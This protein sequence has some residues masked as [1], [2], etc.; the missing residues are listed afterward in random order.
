MANLK[1]LGTVSGFTELAA[2]DNPVPT[3]FVLPAT[4]GTAGQVLATNGNG[5]LSFVTASG[6]S[7]GSG[8]VLPTATTSVLGGVRVD[9][10]TITV[11]GTGV[12][13]ATQYTLPTASSTVLGGV[14]VGTGLTISNG[15]LSVTGGGGSSGGDADRL[16]VGSTYRSA[17]V[18]LPTQGTPFTIACRDLDGNLNAVLFQ[19]TAT[20][21]LFADL[22]E[23]YIADDVYDPGTVLEFGGKFEVTVAS[24]ETT[25][26]AGVVS[27]N[28]GFIMNNGL[29]CIVTEGERT[30][31]VALQGRVPCKV[32]GPVK[33]GDLLVSAGNGF[34]KSHP[35][36][37]LGTVIGKSLEN[38]DGTEGVIEVVVGRQ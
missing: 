34:A 22:A 8:Y 32:L 5:Q 7:G 27:T 33:K 19:G 12:I 3:R 30:A 25:R 37:K 4:D 24:D 13:S 28:P 26:V 17:S 29:E 15:V 2:A 14:R 36:P 9:G 10:T 23:K 11:N 6:G 16:L 20:S 18:D 1:L 31:V 35:E 38:F 21:S